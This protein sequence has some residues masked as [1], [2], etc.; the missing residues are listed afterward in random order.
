M[1]PTQSYIPFTLRLFMRNV[2]FIKHLC[3]NLLKCLAVNLYKCLSLPPA[4]WCFLWVL[5]ACAQLVPL[6]HSRHYLS[7]HHSTL[8]MSEYISFYSRCV[9]IYIIPP[10]FWQGEGSI[11]DGMIPIPNRSTYNIL[12]FIV[13]DIITVTY[14][15]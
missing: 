1:S 4:H 2:L 3:S 11:V 12:F 6:F 14:I 7:T 15:I 5:V 13:Y 8:D 10:P 9:C